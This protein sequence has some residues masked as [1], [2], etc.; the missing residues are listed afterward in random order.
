MINYYLFAFEFGA[1]S[2]FLLVLRREYKNSRL[3][4]ILILAFIYGLFLEIFNTHLSLSYFYSR[5]FLFQIYGVPLAIAAGWGIVYYFT[6][7]LAEKYP[8]KWYEAPFF[9]AFIAVIFDMFLDPIAVRLGFWTWRIPLSEEWFGVPYDNLVGWMAVVWTFAFLINLSESF[10][11]AQGKREFVAP[12]FFQLI[13][14]AS[15]FISPVLLSLQIAIYV[16]LSAI[17]SGRFTI[18]ELLKF[19][20]NSDFGYAYYP[21][22]QAWKFYFFV[23][24]FLFLAVYSLRIIFKRRIVH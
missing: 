3:R 24:I 22:V 2:A 14:Y 23:L 7:K 13:K 6:I 19:Y 1:I 15:V 12:K 11:S 10:D 4:E 8:F 9:M 16:T 18:G 21:E 17:F 5:D 20:D